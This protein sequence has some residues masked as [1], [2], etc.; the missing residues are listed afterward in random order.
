MAQKSKTG[1]HSTRKPNNNQRNPVGGLPPVR[2]ILSSDQEHVS[3]HA[4]VL[5]SAKVPAS[6]EHMLIASNQ[7]NTYKEE[8]DYE[9]LKGKND[10]ILRQSI[11]NSTQKD[12]K[13]S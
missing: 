9:L 12:V 11:T 10:T 3:D 5:E 4:T 1:L 13:T 2:G 7:I 6:E 8:D